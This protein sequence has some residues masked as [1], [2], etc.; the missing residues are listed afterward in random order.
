M[1]KLIAMILIACMAC[2]LVPAMA[3]EDLTGDWYLK[4]MSSEGTEYDAAAMGYSMVITLGADGT[5]SVVE[6]DGTTETGTW[7]VD[8]GTISL[9]LGDDPAVSGPVTDGAFTLDTGSMSMTFTKEAVEAI[10]VAEVTAAESA[11]VFNGEWTCAYIE[12]DGVILDPSS[13]GEEGQM[14]GLT[15]SEEG[16]AFTE[17]ANGYGALFNTLALSKTFENGKLAIASTLEGSD[18]TGTVELL[19]D[20]MIKLSMMSGDEPLILYYAPAAA[21]EEPAA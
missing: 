9:T 1:K 4:T 20:G 7:A 5:A 11:D 19:A 14:P 8:N 6:P 3:D 13:F 15:I 17:T 18:I 2:M 21:A 12:S 10:T 16:F